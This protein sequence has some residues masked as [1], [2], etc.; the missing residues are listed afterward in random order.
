[1]KNIFIAVLTLAILAGAAIL[2]TPSTETENKEVENLPPVAMPWEIIVH[3]DGS[4]EIFKVHLGSSTFQ[5]L[6]KE[7]GM[8][9]SIGLFAK[10]PKPQSVEVWYSNAKTSPM[11]AGVVLTLNVTEQEMQAMMIRSQGLKGSKTGDQ[12]FILADTDQSQLLERTVETLTYIPSYRGLEAD[13]FEERLGVPSATLQ[14]SGSAISWFYPERGLTLMID[15]EGKDVFQ[16]QKPSTFKLP[17]GAIPV[18]KGTEK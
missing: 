16:Y 3:D 2:L 9:D 6:H 8:P 17:A 15:D 13:Y 4:S 5:D 1:M 12:R 7:W 18:E 10:G 11:K 14:E